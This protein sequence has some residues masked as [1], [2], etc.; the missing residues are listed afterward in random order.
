MCTGKGI[1]CSSIES[2]TVYVLRYMS[3]RQSQRKRPWLTMKTFPFGTL[4]RKLTAYKVK[5]ITLQ[6]K[7]N[8]LRQ[9]QFIR[10]IDRICLSAHVS[11]PCIRT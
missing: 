1:S 3:E 5:L 8:P 2:Y 11:S 10:I 9:G 4:E 7:F 6:I